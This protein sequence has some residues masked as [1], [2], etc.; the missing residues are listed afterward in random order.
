[1]G[2]SMGGGDCRSRWPGLE[3]ELLTVP[4]RVLGSPGG[5]HH[6]MV[7]SVLISSC[8]HQR[9]ALPGAVLSQ[10]SEGEGEP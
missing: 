7:H 3:E 10:V 4:V 5:C 6:P 1:M 8:R 2:L 9:D